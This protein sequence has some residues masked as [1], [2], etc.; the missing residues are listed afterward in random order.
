MRIN[1]VPKKLW[2][3]KMGDLIT[4]A[5]GKDVA[6]SMAGFGGVKGFVD[7]IRSQ[8]FALYSMSLAPYSCDN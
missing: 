8:R 5:E 3:M 1:R 7:D 6:T 2:K 4:Q